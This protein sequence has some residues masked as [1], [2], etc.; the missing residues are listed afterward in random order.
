MRRVKKKFLLKKQGFSLLE[1]L[2]STGLLLLMFVGA[3]NVFIYCF[4]LEEISR[5]T[6]LAFNAA[7]AKLEE[8]RNKAM[9]N[10]DF[11]GIIGQYNNKDE[12]ISDLGINLN[13]KIKTLVSYAKKAGAGGGDNTDLINIK[14]YVCWKQK[15]GRIIGSVECGQAGGGG[16]GYFPFDNS[17]IDYV[18]LDNGQTGYLV[19]CAGKVGGIQPSCPTI[20]KCLTSPVRAVGSISKRR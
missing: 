17:L 5:N 2:F 8:I 16:L 7:R 1:I 4:D 6:T 19:L 20:K 11:D 10:Y 9:K 15:R 12:K 14:V 3:M 18:Q 13:G